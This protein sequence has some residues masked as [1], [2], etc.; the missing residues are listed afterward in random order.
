[1]RHR[2]GWAKVEALRC[3][4][5]GHES[6]PAVGMRAIGPCIALFVLLNSSATFGGIYPSPINVAV[7]GAEAVAVG[8]FNGDG[9]LDIALADGA[10]S[11]VEVV[12]NG[13]KGSAG[14]VVSS[15][16]G[17]SA[18][19]SLVVGDFNGDGNLDIA[20]HN[21]FDLNIVVLL[22]N[23]DGSF[24]APLTVN[25]SGAF[26]AAADLNN[27]GNL[28]L[29]GNDGTGFSVL[30]GKGDGSF[31]APTS[32]PITGAVRSLAVADINGDGKSD[33]VAGVDTG[34]GAR[35]RSISATA[36]ELCKPR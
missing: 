27:D 6:L 15:V 7:T 16:S 36:M 2:L 9:K 11:T 13:G 10:T 5:W 4:G 32:T 29:I 30:L 34:S 24:R 19:S 14:S 31:Q 23:G 25:Y 26:C 8:D 22:G 18:P 12:L 17:V 20:L 28:D 1:M 21:R 33:V 35:S 3:G